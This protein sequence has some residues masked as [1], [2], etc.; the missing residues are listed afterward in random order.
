MQLVDAIATALAPIIFVTALGWFA[1][2]RSILKPEAS[3]ILAAFVVRFALPL[4]LFL[5]AATAKRG[6]IL[7]PQLLGTLF[8]GLV[9]SLTI[10]VVVGRMFGHGAAEAGMQGLTGSFGNMAYCGPPVLAA[11]AGSGG[12]LV[13]VLGNLILSIIML[14]IALVLISHGSM[15]G[16]TQAGGF[17]RSIRD[18]VTQPLFFLPVAGLVLALLEVPIPRLLS[19]AVDEIGKSAGGVALFT[20]GLILSGISFRLDRD[21]IANTIMKNVVQP[22]LLLAFGL[23]FGL[24]G[25]SLREAFLLG[26]LPS[27]TAVPTLALAHGVY[28]E[29]AAAS[30]LASTVLAIVT[31]SAGIAI[32]ELL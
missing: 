19:G 7:N 3:G 2:A 8:A 10:G 14:P 9:G 11:V 31:I 27:A 32:A 24:S 26:V 28:A 4:A 22:A 21:V 20:L 12:T 15:D 17:G 25:A 23:L 5:A 29:E 1:G 16:K 13:V 6:D 18:A 30:V